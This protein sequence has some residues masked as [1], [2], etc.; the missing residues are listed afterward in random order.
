MTPLKNRLLNH[1]TNTVV[2]MAG[3]FHM[4]PLIL[5]TKLN[6]YGKQHLTLS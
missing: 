4:P 5:N 6:N 2:G 1:G 3:N